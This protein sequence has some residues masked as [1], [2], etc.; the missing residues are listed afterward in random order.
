MIPGKALRKYLANNSSKEIMRNVKKRPVDNSNEANGR[1]I[2]SSKS[3]TDRIPSANL[4]DSY[5]HLLKPTVRIHYKF[6][7]KHTPKAKV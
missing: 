6:S 7:T 3:K 5:S 2:I 4:S 1:N